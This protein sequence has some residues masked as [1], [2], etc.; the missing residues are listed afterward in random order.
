MIIS[1]S[2]H[3]FAAINVCVA[4]NDMRHML[5]GF[6][7]DLSE[8][9]YCTL[10]ATNGHRMMT[11]EATI[12]SNDNN[13]GN[14]IIYR[15]VKIPRV[16]AGYEV[17]ID[18]DNDIATLHMRKGEQRILLTRI[19]ATFADW[20]RIENTSKANGHK[21]DK[22]AINPEYLADVA[23]ALTSKAQAYPII[24]F[25]DDATKIIIDW[26]HVE[27][28]EKLTYIVMPVHIS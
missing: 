17:S 19:D 27:D 5:N 2:S 28:S 16:K 12:R 15:A 24:Q 11:A 25:S 6:C 20:K 26:M 9:G 22:F 23:K 1:T 4:K 14:S 13:D 10:V 7:L 8:A 3:H 18:T 21:V